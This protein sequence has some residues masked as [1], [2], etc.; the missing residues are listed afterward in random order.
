MWNIMIKNVPDDYV[1]EYWKSIEF[2]E[3]IKFPSRKRN[4]NNSD[5]NKIVYWGDDEISAVWKTSTLTTKS[6]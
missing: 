5:N 2:S 4:Y 1:K 6:F 3:E